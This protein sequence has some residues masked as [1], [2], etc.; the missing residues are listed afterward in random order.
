MPAREIKARPRRFDAFLA[1]DAATIRAAQALR[2]RVFAGEMGARLHSAEPGLDIDEIDAYC[3]HLVVLDRQS[4]QVIGCTR[5]LRDDQAARLGRF[6]SET[7]FHLDGVLVLPGRFLEVGRTCV[8][9]N[10]RG[11]AVIASLWTGLAEYVRN[12]NIDYV[13]GCASIA[14]GPGGFA[15]D[16]IYRGIPPD[17]LGPASLHVSPMRP[18]PGWKR[19]TRDES[20]MPP[21]LQ[22]YLRL[23]ARICGEPCWD[24]DFDVMDVFVLLELKQ[25]QTRYERHFI[26]ARE[27]DT[28]GRGGWQRVAAPITCPVPASAG[29]AKR[30]SPSG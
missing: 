26:G 20:G 17:Q 18:V 12:H 21:L 25:L 13:M 6:Y 2:H 28:S 22:A 11:G 29:Q 23:G 24:E 7:E 5:L 4:R 15:V 16:A 27:P 1:P 9:P 19:C 10:Y 30:L 8:D 14:P 3:D